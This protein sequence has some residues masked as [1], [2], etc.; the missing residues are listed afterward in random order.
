MTREIGFY[1]L[2]FGPQCGNWPRSELLASSDPHPETLLRHSFCCTCWNYIW[3]IDFDILC[4]I[5]SCMYFAILSDIRFGIYS[6]KLSGI[7]SDNLSGILFGN[8]S[9]I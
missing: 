8:L 9:G 2:T 7:Y 3:L 5:V 6:D 1:F 4:D